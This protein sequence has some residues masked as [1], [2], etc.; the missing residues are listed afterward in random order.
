LLH[1][2]TKNIKFTIIAAAFIFIGCSSSINIKNYV[3]KNSQFEL[4]INTRETATQ[5]AQSAQSK[6]AVDS[7]K[8][9]KLMNWLDK[10]EN[11][12]HTTPASFANDILVTQ[13]SFRLLY[14]KGGEGV[15]IGLG[16]KQYSKSIKKGELDF[17]SE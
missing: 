16:D 3:D 8:Y 1:T 12:W 13:N 14:N 5:L 11:G 6:I 2:L 7:E 17:L 9:S 10:N 15:V 4:T